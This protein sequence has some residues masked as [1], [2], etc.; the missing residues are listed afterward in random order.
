MHRTAYAAEQIHLRDMAQT[1]N[2]KRVPMLQL[3][4]P[5]RTH[6]NHGARQ[7]VE[8]HHRAQLVPKYFEICA[9][10]QTKLEGEIFD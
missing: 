3:A 4:G 9:P 6:S 2:K 5:T 10:L 1:E 8:Y 7:N